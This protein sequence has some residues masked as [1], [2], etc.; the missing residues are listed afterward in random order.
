MCFEAVRCRECTAQVTDSTTPVESNINSTPCDADNSEEGGKDNKNDNNST[1]YGDLGSKLYNMHEVLITE[2]KKHK[3]KPQKPQDTA[4]ANATS[5]TSVPPHQ[6][7]ANARAAPQYRYQSNAEDQKLIDQLFHL[8]LEGKVSQAT[9]AQILAASP[10]ICKD[11]VK[12]LRM[13]RIEAG[14]FEHVS[15]PSPLRPA[16]LT[17]FLEP[18]YTVPLQEID[19]LVNG[20]M[21]EAAVIDPGSQ[22]IAIRKDLADSLAMKPNPSAT[23]EMEV[24]NSATSWMLGCVEYLTLQ[25]GDIPFKVH[26]H[27]IE[28]AP[29]RVL[30]GRPF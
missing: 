23:L 26:A 22:I 16:K 12:R 24:A 19:V 4:P 1:N 17:L 9:L 27:V 30:L 25:I 6:P 28:D 3:Y 10:L 18:E 20:R 15:T 11:L 13:R 5:F 29:F 21:T 7:P 14:A 8:L 2:E